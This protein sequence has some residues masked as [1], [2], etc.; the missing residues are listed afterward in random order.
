MKRGILPLVFVCIP[1][2]LASCGSVGKTT[3]EK[4]SDQPGTVSLSPGEAGKIQAPS[5][6]SDF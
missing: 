6:P 1:F 4:V 2:V 3:T 5:K